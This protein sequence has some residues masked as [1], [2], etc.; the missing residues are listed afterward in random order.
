MMENLV[1]ALGRLHPLIVHLPIGFLLLG[2]FFECISLLRR[3]RRLETAVSSTMFVGAI[4]AL[5]A[6]VSG[7]LLKGEGGY[8]EV[9]VTQHLYL[10]ISTTVLA[11][12]LVVV[13]SRIRRVV[14]NPISRRRINLA[15][16]SVL[17][18]LLSATG[19]LG[20]SLTHGDDYLTAA[21]AP[22]HDIDPLVEIRKI[23]TVD[24]ADLYEQI[25]KPL[26]SARCYSCHSSAS[27]K[28]KLRLD[29]EEFMRK[30]GKHGSALAEG[31]PDSSLLYKL[32]TLP[33]DDDHHM[34]PRE[35]TQMSS[36]EIDLIGQW[37]ENGAPFGGR[38]AELQNADKIIV[39]DHGEIKEM[40]SHQQLLKLNGHYRR[41]YDL[42]FNSEGIG[43]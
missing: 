22:Q 18:V 23:A 34:P 29:S 37:L 41:L 10:G 19:H 16:S 36:T 42:Q 20:G 11:F 9:I 40:G 3:Y 25:V 31:V 43:R 26:L 33:I 6:S 24:S 15:L 30:G 27:Q 35:K 32:L 21:F 28:G 4:A 1:I 13:R 12:I 38:I 39:L 8:D 7:W 2:F 5:F 17:V 14:V